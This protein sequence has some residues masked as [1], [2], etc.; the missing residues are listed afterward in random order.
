MKKFVTV[1]ISFMVLFIFLVLNYLLW[2]K[3]NLL[4]LSD[5]AKVEQDWLRGQNRTLQTTVDELEQS[6]KDLDDQNNIQKDKIVDLEQQLGTAL[7]REN[8]NLKTIQT[9]NDAL[10]FYKSFMKAKLKEVSGQ[11]FSDISNN[12][13]EHSFTYLDKNFKLWEKFYDTTQYMEF[14]SAFQNIEIKKE[15]T[16]D[17]QIFDILKDQEDPYEIRARVSVNISIKKDRQ[18][19]FKNINDG[20]NTLELVFRY[21]TDSSNWVIKSVSTIEIGKP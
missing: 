2:D 12:K 10:S 11:W 21:D 15:Q 1:I 7:K 18:P 19:D 14:I 4:K 5:N 9:Q 13:A 20:L 3:E 8:D 6:V 17:V 16:D